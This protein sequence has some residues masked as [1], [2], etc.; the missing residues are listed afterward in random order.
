[1]A[2]ILTEQT[3]H[4]LVVELTLEQ[5]KRLQETGYSLLEQ[6]D[7]YVVE[8]DTNYL[9]LTID[10]LGELDYFIACINYP[11]A[12]EYL[13]NNHYVQAARKWEKDAKQ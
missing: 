8:V 12:Q 1:M 2:K 9:Y 11:E 10:S 13:Q 7:D 5:A 4:Q 3:V 6:F